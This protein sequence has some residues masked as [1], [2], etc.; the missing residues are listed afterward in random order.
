MSDL[1]GSVF[2]SW[3]MFFATSRKSGGSGKLLQ[4]RLFSTSASLLSTL[5]L[6]CHTLPNLI[7]DRLGAH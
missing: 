4:G 2:L 3:L 7:L 1:N 6:L 5:K